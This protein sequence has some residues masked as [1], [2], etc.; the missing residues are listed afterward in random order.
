[1]GRIEQ[2]SSPSVADHHQRSAPSPVV[3]GR[4]AH[5]RCHSL[6]GVRGPCLRLTQAHPHWV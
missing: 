3:Q 1:V 2:V 6:L 5:R 4:S